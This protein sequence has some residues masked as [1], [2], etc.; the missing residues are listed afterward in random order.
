MGAAVEKGGYD[1][2]LRFASPEVRSFVTVEE[3][4]EAEDNAKMD[5]WLATLP[6]AVTKGLAPPGI[7]HSDGI[8]EPAPEFH[9]CPDGF[10]SR[11][12]LRGGTLPTR[13]ENFTPPPSP[14]SSWA[15][16]AA[17]PS[18]CRS[19]SRKLTRLPLSKANSNLTP[20]SPVPKHQQIPSAI[21][22]LLPPKF[23]N[24]FSDNK[25]PSVRP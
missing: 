7:Y 10:D 19:P 13:T 12:G 4:I 9:P 24:W 23:G 11:L 22:P 3:Q 20:P 17:T 5:A 18:R 25:Q 21:E 14:T 15:E 1:G 2:W 16:V 6:E 8:V